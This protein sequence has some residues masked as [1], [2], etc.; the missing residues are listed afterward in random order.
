[1]AN[2]HGLEAIGVVPSHARYGYA[3]MLAGDAQALLI[4]NLD[5]AVD[6]V[7]AERLK[8]LEL[9]VVHAAF[10]TATAELA[11]VV[12]PAATAYEKDGTV[13]NLEGRMLPVRAAPIDNGEA[14]DLTGVVKALGEAL[15]TRLEGRS[16]RSARRWLKKSVGVDLEALPDLGA[17]LPH[18]RAGATPR[19]TVATTPGAPPVGGLRVPT[20]ARAEVLDRNPHL[21]RATGGLKLRLHPKDAA[22]ARASTP[23]TWSPC[24]STASAAPWS[25]R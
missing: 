21:N 7:V 17:M 19:T 12:L 10:R 23:T 3:G 18:K 13:V 20:M 4:S 22:R 5:P 24:R 14:T 25:F 8:G 16:V 15:G 6:A 11:H 9:L 1:M 2:S